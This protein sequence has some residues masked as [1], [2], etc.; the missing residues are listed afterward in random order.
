[1][2]VND[3]DPVQSFV[4]GDSRRDDIAPAQA[5]G[6]KAVLVEVGNHSWEYDHAVVADVPTIASLADLPSI[7]SPAHGWWEKSLVGES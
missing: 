2:D 4:I 5:L 7:V 1:V 6:L 3:V